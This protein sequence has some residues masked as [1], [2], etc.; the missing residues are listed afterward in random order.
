MNK[1]TIKNKPPFSFLHNII[2]YNEKAHKTS[3][4]HNF[5]FIYK[6]DTIT[7]KV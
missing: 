3:L 4:E 1:L 5:P 2:A 7:S 6:E